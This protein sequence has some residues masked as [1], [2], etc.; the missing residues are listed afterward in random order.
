MTPLQHD[1]SELKR[2]LNASWTHFHCATSIMPSQHNAEVG[3]GGIYMLPQ[4]ISTSPQTSWTTDCFMKLANSW[5]F[6]V[7]KTPHF[8]NLHKPPFI[9]RM[10]QKCVRKGQYGSVVLTQCGSRLVIYPAI[11]IIFLH[12]CNRFSRYLVWIDKKHS[13]CSIQLLCPVD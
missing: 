3:W 1:G 12:S 4:A 9:V 7:H 10:S 5:R 13:L 8:T 6:I 11:T 2:H